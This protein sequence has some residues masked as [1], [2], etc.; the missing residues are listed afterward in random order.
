MKAYYRRGVAKLKMQNMKGIIDINQSLAL[1]KELFEVIVLLFVQYFS[2]HL[3]FLGLSDVSL[4][5]SGYVS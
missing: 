4:C 3:G 2:L 5:I 1:N